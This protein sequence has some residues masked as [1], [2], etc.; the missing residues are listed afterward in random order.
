MVVLGTCLGTIGGV[1]AGY[2]LIRLQ[3]PSAPTSADSNG[4]EFVVRWPYLLAI[5]VGIPVLATLLAF[6]ATRS[7]LTLTHRT[8]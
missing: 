6:V 5:T 7:R 8:T 2:A 3:M 4:W 1:L